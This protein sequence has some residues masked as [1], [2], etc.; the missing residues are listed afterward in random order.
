[1]IHALQGVAHGHHDALVPHVDA[2]A[3]I[4]D[5]IGR[6]SSADL[7]ERLAAEHRFITAQL[8][9]HLEQAEQTL[10]PALERLLQNRHS[11]TPMRREH[12]LLR[13]LIA[14]L[15][16]L[17]TRPMEF[18]VQ[19][20]LRRVL[21]RMYAMLKIHLAEEQAYLTVLE[22]NLSR[23]EEDELAHGMAH[24]MADLPV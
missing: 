23:E 18:G 7:A 22:H 15:A 5:E 2:L 20:R 16:E 8:V 9:P 6:G 10:Y 19:L 14:E 13:K 11:M 12:E 24:A 1:M 4:A 21:Y 3:A 17:R